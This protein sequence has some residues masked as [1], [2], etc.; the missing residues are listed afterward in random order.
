MKLQEI[1]AGCSFIQCPTCLTFL[2]FHPADA[3][4]E[5]IAQADADHKVIC[6]GAPPPEL[7][8]CNHGG[9]RHCDCSIES[10]FCCWCHTRLGSPW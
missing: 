1:P 4:P 2:A 6:P 7:V 10:G 3:T 5:G 9:T 8:N